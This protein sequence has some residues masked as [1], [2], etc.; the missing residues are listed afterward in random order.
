[1][2]EFE[3]EIIWKDNITEGDNPVHKSNPLPSSILSKAGHVKSCLNLPGPSGKAK[4]L[5]ETDSEPVP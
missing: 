1:M 2:C 4:Y 3:V 5:Q